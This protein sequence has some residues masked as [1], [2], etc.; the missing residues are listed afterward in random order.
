MIIKDSK[1]I[2]LILEFINDHEI[3]AYDIES[4]SLD[5]CGGNIIGFGLSN[6][7]RGFYICHLEYDAESDNLVERVGYADCV[8]ILKALQSKKLITWNGSFDS[9]FTLNYFGV[10]LIDSLWS[11]GM[12]LKHT[13]DEERPFGL[14]DVG[15]KLFGDSAAEE[16][17]LMKESI[18]ANGGTTHQYFK[19]DLDI[20]GN[21]CIKDCILT[22]AINDHYL[23]IIEK[24]GL[25][26]FYF[27]DEVMPLYKLVTIPME[28]KGVALDI[29]TIEQAKDGILTDITSLEYRIQKAIKP[30][31]Y[32]FELW[33]LN[34]ELPPKRSGEF[35][36]YIC[37]YGS[38]DLPLTKGGRFS[39]LGKNIDNLP[40]SVYRTFLLGGD[41][42]DEETVERIQRKW[43]ADQEEGYMFNLSSKFHL[44]KIFFE[45]L[46]ETPLS[47]TPTGQPQVNDFFLEDM[48]KKH[49]WVELLQQYNKLNKLKSTYI[50]RML[51]KQID[52]ILYP[53]WNMHRTTSGRLGGDLMQLPRPLEPGEAS[54]L[55]TKYTN[56]IRHFVIAGDNKKLVGADYNSLEVVV[57]ADDSG[58]PALLDMIR[59]GEDFYSSVACKVWN[60]TQYSADKNAD[61][62]L[63]KHE[64]AMRQAAKSFSLGI[65]YGMQAF[66]LSK[67][68]DISQKEAEGIIKDYFISYPRLKTRME[69]LTSQATSLGYVKSKG[70]RVRH[71]KTL[72]RLHYTHG[73]DLGDSLKL[74][75]KYHDSPKKYE[76]M[77]YLGKQYKNF[78]NNCLNFPIQSMAATIT[79][80]ACIALAK[81]FN[82]Q[83]LDAYI[84]MQVHDEVVVRCDADIAEKVG[85]LMKFVLE[86]TTKLSVPLNADPEIGDRYGQIK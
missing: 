44:K 59:S 34:K 66:K 47:K 11:D 9:R 8:I 37:K 60:L 71:L 55:V 20:M 27:K 46:Q 25:S 51:E 36:Q 26:D 2:N 54:K 57:F 70:G 77:K 7:A 18:K 1:D 4:D 64:P 6:A 35:A 33:F 63:K 74:W 31:S 42:L 79:N 78:K 52:G 48:A 49:P 10:N 14:K 40:D 23:N 30:L 29:N 61:N 24:E 16:Q 75:S 84:C 65:R 67:E 38:L 73:E 19:A 85:K 22:Y 5:T 69:A 12:L 41:Y 86:N 81:E 80:K 28:L 21:Y 53:S 13:A 39:L 50:D 68:L 76:Q 82:R 43:W 45:K 58:D 3:L 15:K 56:M 17:R 72:K 83:N 32:E 62:Y